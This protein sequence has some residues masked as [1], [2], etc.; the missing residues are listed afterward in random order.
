MT[1]L[2]PYRVL[3]LTTEMGILGPRL[4]AG[5]G[6][7]VIRVEPT[8]GDPLRRYEPFLGRDPAS[9]SLYW[10]QMASG[11]KSVAIDLETP[12]GADSF[13]AL[14]ATADFVIESRHPELAALGL[15][16]DDIRDRNPQIVWVSITPFGRTGPRARW[17]SSDLIAMAAGGLMYL[18]GDRDRAPVRVTVEQAYAQVGVNAAAA[19]M[20][21]HH[22]RARLGVGQLVDVSMQEAVVNA[23]GNARL[24]YAVEQLVNERAGGGRSFGSSGVRLIYPSSD[25]FIAFW[26]D[27]G[28][29]APLATWLAG[30]GFEVGFDPAEWATLPMTG[31]AQPRREKALEFERA[32][33]PLFTS[34]TTEYLYE[35]GQS[36]GIMI[37]P[38][39][40]T[41]DLLESPQLNARGFFVET[42]IAGTGVTAKMP[43]APFK[44]SA[45]PW[46]DLCP[47][48][49]TPG[50]HNDEVLSA[51]SM[52]RKPV[53]FESSGST[54]SRDTF[55]GMRVADF[56]WVGV[57]PNTTQS[58]AFMGAEVI[59]VESSL[60][61][62]TFRYSGP[63]QPGTTGLD[64]SAYYANYNRD[65]LSVAMNLRHPKA[66]EAAR[67]FV[68]QADVMAESFTPGFL[69]AIGLD[70]DEVRKIR[71]DMVMISMS[72]EGQGGPHAEFKG[73]GLTLQATAGITHLT[74]WPDRAPVGTGVAYTDWFATYLASFALSA[75]LDHRRRTG[76]G[77]Y[78]DLSQLEAMIHGLDAAV[79]EYAANGDVAN[80]AGNRHPRMAPH[81]VYP[82]A[83]QD[84]WIA[85]AV[86]HDTAWLTLCDVLGQPA[87]AADSRLATLAG[88]LEHHDELDEK[89]AA[90]TAPL[91][92]EVLAQA[93][94]ARGVA[95]HIVAT[96]A[97]LEAD[98]Q[99]AHR[100]HNW[101][102]PHP[103]LGPVGL[104]APSWRLTATPL[105]PGRPSPLLGQHNEYVYRE[106]LGYS[107]DEFIELM[108]EHAA[109]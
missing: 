82:V 47:A 67:R 92:G 10:A 40:T 42:E 19:A 50:Q 27:S 78:I 76:E 9:V 57:G 52:A 72:M 48:P 81:G 38:V 51:A 69:A 79:L 41:A 32:V 58:L 31:P 104:D 105:Y 5:T 71:P 56:S 85:I 97:D 24:Y 23:L 98:P 18:C 102:T 86:H 39:A 101:R 7:E 84:R 37:C 25:G 94:Q 83:G 64:R 100:E 15:D 13:R 60:K 22:V 63:Y 62:D 36:R 73:F 1:A 95:A 80:R 70:Y 93:L 17:H 34:R 12:A 35:V 46:V 61:P 26:R 88:R 43:G 54:D 21:A 4:F 55:K 2:A 108:A 49:A 8:A 66:I 109:E 20:L 90:I 87:L 68:A 28:S 75:A 3:D 14:V 6:A 89:L 11:R 33:E 30:E 74:G 16:Y 59:R 99:L 77:Q 91:D 96:T 53:A 106:L 44:M 107:E 29:Y 103:I 65:K 45:T